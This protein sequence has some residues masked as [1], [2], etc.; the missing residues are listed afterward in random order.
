MSKLKCACSK[1]KGC[2]GFAF[3]A[4]AVCK[5]CLWGKHAAKKA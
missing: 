2:P 1:C 5:D 3:G 4:S